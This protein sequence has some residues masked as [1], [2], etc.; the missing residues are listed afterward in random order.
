MQLVK[1]I[2]IPSGMRL[3]VETIPKKIIC[4][5]PGMQPH[6]YAGGTPQSSGTHSYEMRLDDWVSFFYRKMQSYGL[7][8]IR[9]CAAWHLAEC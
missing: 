5:P 1:V 3:S 9:I 4:I 6:C 2:S 7:H 8:V